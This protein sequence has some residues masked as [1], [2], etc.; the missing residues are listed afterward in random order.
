MIV[1]II[2]IHIIFINIIFIT[3]VNPDIIEIKFTIFRQ[4][5]I[6][7]SFPFSIDLIKFMDGGN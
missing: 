1:F 5:L 6:S 4:L 2:Y 3:V 7:T